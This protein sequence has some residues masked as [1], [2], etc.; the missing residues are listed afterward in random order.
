MQ[1]FIYK[2]ADALG[3]KLVLNALV[4]V[5]GGFVG[6]GLECSCEG[7]WGDTGVGFDMLGLGHGG[8]M[9]QGEI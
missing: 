6:R 5:L 4:A 8:R 7:I 1:L 3:V 2:F 9:G